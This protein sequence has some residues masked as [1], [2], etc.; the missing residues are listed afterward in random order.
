MTL[1]H[2]LLANG[3]AVVALLGLGWAVLRFEAERY[4]KA[5]P[6][7]PIVKDLGRVAAEGRLLAAGLGLTPAEAAHWVAGYVSGKG[8]PV[9]A[10][11]LEAGAAAVSKAAAADQ[12]ALGG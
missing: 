5:H 9:T 10:A 7:S 12:V 8:V 4:A 6:N 1:G 3:S 11:Q 2:L